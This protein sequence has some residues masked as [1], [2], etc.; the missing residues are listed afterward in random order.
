MINKRL[1]SL[2][3]KR[4][5][6][7]PFQTREML[8]KI[9]VNL[10]ILLASIHI[11]TQMR[12]V[13]HIGQ[14]SVDE[15][16]L[17]W[18]RLGAIIIA[19]LLLATGVTFLIGLVYAQFDGKKNHFWGL[20]VA[21][22]LAAAGIIMFIPTMS[23]VHIIYFLV[24]SVV[25]G[26]LSILLTPQTQ[27]FGHPVSPYFHF[28]RLI[29]YRH[30]IRLWV[31]YRI[32]SRYS[33]TILGLLWI[34][35]LPLSTSIILSVVFSQIIRAFDVGEVPFI[36]FFLAGLF[37]WNLFSNGLLQGAQT[38][39]GSM[40]LIN[41]I[42]FPREILIFVKMGELVVD[43]LFVLLSVIIINSVLGVY[44]SLYLLYLPLVLVIEIGFVLGAVL[45]A[46]CVSVFI[47]DI[48]QLIGVAVQIIFYL[49]PILYPASII[50]RRLQF[51]LL[52]NPL[53]PLIEAYRDI[54]I[55]Q[56]PPDFVQLITPSI[57][58]VLLLYTGYM[59]FK[60]NEQRIADFV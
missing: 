15:I 11:S 19:S 12:L 33:Q 55:Y 43:L 10:L 60:K 22:A 1:D 21:S 35:L 31:K 29:S 36:S 50:P 25:I 23:P 41:Q 44:P 6:P 26:V 48:P 30:L 54:L 51:I 20:V 37:G 46:S 8:A 13:I 32:L 7:H 49:T 56:R 53:V 58:A 4:E 38:L 16:L 34:I 59:F 2:Y 45:F 47:R 3:K 17:P 5:Q 40:I 52:V 28:K 24:V 18:F 27:A 39:L 9:L 57:V 42:Y 14:D